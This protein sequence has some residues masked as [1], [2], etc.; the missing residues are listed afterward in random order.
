MSPS[1]WRGCSELRS[2]AIGRWLIEQGAAPWDRG[3]P[4]GIAVTPLASNG[5]SARLLKRQVHP[6]PGR[7]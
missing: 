3:K 5:F 7:A 1:F 6:G 4:P 2:A